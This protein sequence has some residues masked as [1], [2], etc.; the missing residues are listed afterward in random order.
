MWKPS[1]ARHL[2]STSSITCSHSVFDEAK[3]ERGLA[4]TASASNDRHSDSPSVTAA[5]T[6]KLG[7]ESRRLRANAEAQSDP[8]P[9]TNT[10]IRRLHWPINSAA[11]SQSL[12]G[13]AL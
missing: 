12:A 2:L 7:C 11:A 4:L 5:T 3:A 10:S 8:D 6:F 1:P 13:K 9:T